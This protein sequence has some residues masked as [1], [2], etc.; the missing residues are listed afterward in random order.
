MDRYRDDWHPQGRV[1]VRDLA[2][3]FGLGF[4]PPSYPLS[5]KGGVWGGVES[6][7]VRSSKNRIWF[8][9]IK[10][11]ARGKGTIGGRAQLCELGKHMF[12]SKK[13]FAL[14]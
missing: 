11:K 2:N 14:P 1:W 10:N 8:P 6:Q 13:H 7:A 9:E 3:V 12:T 4:F 5:Q